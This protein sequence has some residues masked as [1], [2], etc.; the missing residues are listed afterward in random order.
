MRYNAGKCQVIFISICIIQVTRYLIACASSITK[1]II[2]LTK[3]ACQF[4]FVLHKLIYMY[5]TVQ[6]LEFGS[7][8]VQKRHS[9]LTYLEKITA[10]W[11]YVSKSNIYFVRNI[12]SSKIMSSFIAL[13]QSLFNPLVIWPLMDISYAHIIMLY[14]NNLHF[15]VKSGHV[16]NCYN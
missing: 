2:L 10:F 12:L 9:Q 7:F 6:K 3:L 5:S 13:Y 15:S 16:Y 11:E 14:I 8:V 4:K 1:L